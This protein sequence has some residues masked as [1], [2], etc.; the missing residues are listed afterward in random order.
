MIMRR[1]R[2]ILTWGRLRSAPKR[3]VWAA[4]GPQ[5]LSELL[6]HRGERLADQA[7]DVHLREAHALR[8]LGLGQA[9]LEAHP[10]DLALAGGQALER[11]R[12]RGAL[13]RALE[14]DPMLRQVDPFYC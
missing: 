10:E 9:L 11:G 1:S 4:E 3:R 2:R 14:P 13:L 6:P 7:G 5:T 12:Q 8:D